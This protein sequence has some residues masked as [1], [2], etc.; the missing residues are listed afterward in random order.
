[1]ERPA[2]VLQVR[3]EPGVPDVI[4]SL[5]SWLKQGLRAH[6]LRCVSIEE[7]NMAKQHTIGMPTANAIEDIWQR[8]ATAAAIAA[9]RQVIDGDVIPKTTSIGRLTDIELGWLIIAG[10]FAWIR[11]RAE[12]ATAEGWDTEQTLRTLALSPPAWDAGAVAYI[13]PELAKIDGVDWSRPVGSW[14]KDTVIHFL[15]TAMNLIAAAMAARDVSGGGIAT[16]RK[17]VE[18]I[19]RVASAEAGGPLAAPGELDDGLLGL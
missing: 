15:L 12:Q 9:V 6:G 16:N 1:M 3:P 14:S 7:I 10:L 8:R 13:L 2:F 17:S 19:Q 5:R 11:T 4:R 18:E